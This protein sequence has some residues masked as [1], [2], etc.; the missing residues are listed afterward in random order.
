MI[1]AICIC[2]DERIHYISFNNQ[3]WGDI[4][5]TTC[6]VLTISLW[7][8]WRDQHTQSETT[9]LDTKN[10]EK[11]LSTSVFGIPFAKTEMHT[12][13]DITPAQIIFSETKVLQNL[14]LGYRIQSSLRMTPDGTGSMWAHWDPLA[15]LKRLM[16]A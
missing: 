15:C 7:V 8:L 10:K 14:H 4:L 3:L 9:Q 16:V 2:N 12:G 1:I 13:F 11:T 6:K 5:S